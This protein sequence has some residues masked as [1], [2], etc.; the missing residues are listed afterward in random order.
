MAGSRGSLA[1]IERVEAG[2]HTFSELRLL[3]SLRCGAVGL[4]AEEVTV[5]VRLLSETGS[6]LASRLG[7]P[8]DSDG[9][10]VKQ[11]LNDQLTRWHGRAEAPNVP[12]E[13]RDAASVL[14]RTCEGHLHDLSR[15]EGLRQV[16]SQ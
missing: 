5:A 1:E 13:V 3:D 12:E 2:A 15:T 16:A 14:I 6:S 8:T 7:I 11:A 9:A 4:P 10:Q